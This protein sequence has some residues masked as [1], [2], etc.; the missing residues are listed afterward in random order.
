MPPIIDVQPFVLKDILLTLATLGTS[1]VTGDYQ[2]HVSAAAFTPKAD[3]KTWTGLGNNT[4]T[5]VGT[6]T[7]TCDLTYAQDWE[8]DDSLSQF[9]M[10]HEGEKI[11]ATFEPVNGVGSSFAATLTVTPGA[12]GGKGG[13]FLEASVSLGSTKPVKTAVA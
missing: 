8:T 10:D 9:L 3:V 2:K 12:I 5:D 1:P 13:D 7:W 6:A 11:I 4:V